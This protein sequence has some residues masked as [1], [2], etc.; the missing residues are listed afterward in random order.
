VFGVVSVL[1][2][3]SRSLHSLTSQPKRLSPGSSDPSATAAGGLSRG[4]SMSSIMSA[5]SL[6]SVASASQADDCM[7]FF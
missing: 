3:D 6:G 7:L 4:D 2:A 1:E 5:A